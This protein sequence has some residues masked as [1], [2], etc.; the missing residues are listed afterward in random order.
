MIS[1]GS[2]FNDHGG[3][4]LGCHYDTVVEP[5]KK[6][7]SAIKAFTPS[8]KKKIMVKIRLFQQN[9]K[10]ARNYLRMLIGL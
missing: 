9:G 10:T 2:I 6:T 8:A 5:A 1:G 3:S 4:F 7:I